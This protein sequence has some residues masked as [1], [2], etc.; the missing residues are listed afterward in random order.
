MDK[1]FLL[2]PKILSFPK[3]LTSLFHFH[4]R[5]LMYFHA[6]FR[7]QKWTNSE[8]TLVTP[9]K[10]MV[11]PPLTTSFINF[12]VIKIHVMSY[13]DRISNLL[14]SCI[15]GK[16]LPPW[17]G[18]FIRINMRVQLHCIARIHV[19][20]L[21]ETGW[22]SLLLSWYNPLLAEPPFLLGPQRKNRG[23]VPTVHHGRK[24][25]LSRDH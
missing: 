24:D 25:S 21:F 9:K 1:P 18:G 14:P 10:R 15:A 13:R 7:P 22:T 16:D 5:V 6:L 4:S 20:Y 2:A 11:T 8:H 12:I 3:Q 23:L 19:V 17:K